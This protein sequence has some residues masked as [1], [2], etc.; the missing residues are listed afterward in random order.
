[1][2]AL[3]SDAVADLYKLVAELE[4][5]LE[6]SFAAH[7]EAIARQAAT[8]IEN[9]RLI[10]ELSIARE[11]QNASAD[12]LHT[13]ANAKGDAERALHQIAEATMRLFDAP[14]A[15]IHIADGDGWS[16]VIRAGEGSR[17]VG[18]GVPESQL[19][20]GGR[21]MPG[22]IV[23]ENRQVHVPDLDNVDPAIADWPGL[24]YVRAAGTRSM[25]GSPLRRDGRAIGVLIVYRD[26]LAPFTD[27]EMALQQSFAD[28]AAIA[29]ENARLFNETREALERQ[30]AT[31]EIL[32]VIAA[33]PS[34]AQP[35]FEAIADSAKRLL[36]G[37]S[38]TVLRFIG[39][40]LHLVAFTPTDPAADA[41]LQ[42]SFPRSISEFPTFALV[43]TGE[44]VQFPDSEGE[45]VPELNRE[46]ARLRGFRSVL[47]T[48]LMNRGEP[49]G[50]IS[51][52]RAEPGAFAV[53][54]VQLL[55]TF[56]DQAVI[57]I[58]NARLFNET[59]QAL[60]RQT[61]TSDVLKVIA[62]SPSDVQPVFEA[63]VASANR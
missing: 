60:E 47:F 26:K 56:A 38:A 24:P 8:D 48:P 16:Q 54:H 32:K 1:M 17:S 13:I 45:H 20:I 49:V 52:T 62:G 43:R 44:T 50:M 29:I 63:I 10:H 58:E 25:S 35:V 18:A 51:V 22:T 14:S 15:T 39:D 36:G 41:G 19:K 6:S 53:D 61:A 21:N 59:R 7:D 55:Q 28:Q 42:A 57:A 30:T 46:L 9:G 37:F 4:Q 33:S 11:Q 40:E 3:P 31:A 2:T 23:A 27:E 34:D 12:I 5:R